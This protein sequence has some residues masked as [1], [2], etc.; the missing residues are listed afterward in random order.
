MKTKT[1][2]LAAVLPVVSS[3]ASP[4]TPSNDQP[5]P[6]SN[7]AVQKAITTVLSGVTASINGTRSGSRGLPLSQ[8]LAAP[9]AMPIAS[10]LGP[11]FTQQCNASG[12][13]CSIQFNESFNQPT[14]C[15][16][17]GSSNTSA[18][19]T[20]VIQG[21]AT[22]LSGTL[23]LSVRSTFTDCSEGGWVTNS[24]PSLS[25]NGQMF[26]TSQHTRI[27]LTMS[28]GM[29]ISNAPGA[30]AGRSSCVTNG[31]LLQWDDITGNW[32]DSGSIDCTPGGSFRFQ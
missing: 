20:G 30:P 11:A 24:N 6:A 15:S 31:V 1:W 5:V 27:N 28:G 8:G 9:L 12:T 4:T 17:G 25:T 7:A 2:L 26:I 23:N 19:L 22:S 32:A 16:G 10:V 13:S 3:C 18:T 21:G 14:N 29:V